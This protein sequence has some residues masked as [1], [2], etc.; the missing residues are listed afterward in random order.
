MMAVIVREKHG[1]F[2]QFQHFVKYLLHLPKIK[3]IIFA[4]TMS[5]KAAEQAS[6][7]FV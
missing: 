7:K 5:W 3:C 1:N 4:N 2:Q 6:D